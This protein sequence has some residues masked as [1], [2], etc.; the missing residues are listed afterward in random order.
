MKNLAIEPTLKLSHPLSRR[1]CI[2][3]R[4]MATLLLIGLLCACDFQKPVY[5]RQHNPSVLVSVSSD[6]KLIAVVENVG[7]PSQRLRIKWTDKDERWQE[8]QLP[9]HTNSIQF[10]LEGYDLLLSHA[11]HENI[12]MS[13]I[14]R[15]NVSDGKYAVRTIYQ[16]PHLYA[17]IE[18]KPDIYI[19]RT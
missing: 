6:G 19:A 14:I 3:A 15:W 7:T 10:A 11:L 18:V 2:F 5:P 12:E 8:Q 9:M 1:I 4:F 16:A 17:P 13:Q